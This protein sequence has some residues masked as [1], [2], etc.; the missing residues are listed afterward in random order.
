M[1]THHVSSSDVEMEAGLKRQHSSSPGNKKT[2]KKKEE[3]T[4]EIKILQD[5][6]NNYKKEVKSKYS[7]LIEENKKIK[8]E[9]EKL[10][11]QEI[12]FRIKEGS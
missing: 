8:E 4:S 10:Q 12:H 3:D 5:K 9:L 7:V 2:K 11:I 1:K 6:F